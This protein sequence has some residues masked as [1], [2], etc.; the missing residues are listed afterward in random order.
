MGMDVKAY[1]FIHFRQGIEG[2]ERDEN[3]IT[4]T[5]VVND[6]AAG[7]LFQQGA[8]KMCNHLES[9]PIGVI[10]FIKS[11]PVQMAYR[12]GQ[13]VRCVC[14][15]SSLKVQDHLDHRTNLFLGRPAVTHDRLF[16]F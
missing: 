2:G 1:L 12:S 14:N 10:S 15:G 13:G 11:R 5:G 6:D 16:D 4:D 7:G 9:G 8:M 3:L